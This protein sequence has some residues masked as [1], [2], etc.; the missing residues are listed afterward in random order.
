[1]QGNAAAEHIE[2]R[3]RIAK[4]EERVTLIYD[5][6]NPMVRDVKEISENTKHR[7][8]YTAGIIATLSLLLGAGVTLIIAFSGAN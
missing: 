1:M 5:L 6:V 4:I 2:L 3:E 7:A 8:G